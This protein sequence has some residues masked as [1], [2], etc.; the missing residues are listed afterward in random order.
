[1]SETFIQEIDELYKGKP[2]LTL[3]DL[4]L[5]LGCSRKVVYNLTRAADLKSRPPLMRVGKAILFPKKEFFRWLAET[6][7]KPGGP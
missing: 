7:G 1:M 5:V 4:S 3:D 2:F 6:H